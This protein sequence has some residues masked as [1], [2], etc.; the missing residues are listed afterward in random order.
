MQIK[1]RL[2]VTTRSCTTV[3]I[4]MYAIHYN[5]VIMSAMASQITNLTIVYSNVHIE[6]SIKARRHWPLCG[7][8]TGDLWIPRTNGQYR[9]K[10]FH[11]MT[12]S[13]YHG[14]DHIRFECPFAHNCHQL[15]IQWL[16]HQN[17]VSFTLYLLFIILLITRYVIARTI[18]LEPPHLCQNS[19]INPNNW[20]QNISSTGT[21]TSNVFK[22]I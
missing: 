21:L 3:E 2:C 14:V 15:N 20:H 13:R 12:P 8:F 10:C 9:K 1:T 16:Q 19:E 11:L 18:S 22:E 5:D 6:G 7:E 4:Y 17:N